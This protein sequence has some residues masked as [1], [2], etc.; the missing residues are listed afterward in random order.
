MRA[1]SAPSPG[2]TATSAAR[3]ALRRRWSDSIRPKSSGATGCAMATSPTIPG[4]STCSARRSSSRAS[5]TRRPA[6]SSPPP[7]T[8]LPE[9]PG[10]ERNWDYRFSWIRDSTFTLWAL[11]TLGFD[12]EARD[13][14]RFI[15]DL[16]REDP[17]LQIMYGIGGEKELTE[18][19]LDH[20]GG[21]A[22]G[23]SR[24]GSATVPSTRTSTTSGALAGLP[25]RASENARAAREPGRPRTDRQQVEAAIAAWPEP[26]SGDLGGARGAQA[27]RLLEADVLGGRRP[28]DAAGPRRRTRRARRRP[29][30]L[31]RSYIHVAETPRNPGCRDGIFRQHFRDRRPRR[32][33]FC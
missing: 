25:L 8:S 23:A 5:P 24:S 27:L 12:Q 10:G 28:G 7:T 11:H 9:T 26:R 15:L 16:C 33:E 14:M 22:S 1:A 6:R 18:T 17:N 30:A 32:F 29:P 3:A 31:C 2:G 21:Y 4:A 20:L 13:F 19:T